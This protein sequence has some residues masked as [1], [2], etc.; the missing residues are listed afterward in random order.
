VREYEMSEPISLGDQIE[1]AVG[2]VTQ[3]MDDVYTKRREMEAATRLLGEARDRL[4]SLRVQEIASPLNKTP[5]RTIDVGR[6][7]RYGGERFVRVTQT[8]PLSGVKWNA[9][10]KL[11]KKNTRFFMPN[12]LVEFPLS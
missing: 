8:K 12:D 11:T 9:I 2:E 3:L 6:H 10:S 7:F 4:S 1:L 5:F